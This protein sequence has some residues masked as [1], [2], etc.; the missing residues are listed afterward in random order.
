M[1]GGE[2]VSS[3]GSNLKEEQKRERER[4]GARERERER[5]KRRKKSFMRAAFHASEAMLN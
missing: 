3:R 1:G 2:G 5:E 4:D